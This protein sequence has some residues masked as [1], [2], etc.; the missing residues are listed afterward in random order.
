MSD[1]AYERL[2]AALQHHGSKV[3]NAGADRFMAQCP[4][5][6][7]GRP[8]LS[9]RRGDRCTL[10]YCFAGCDTAAIMDALGLTTRDL[11]DADKITYSYGD[12]LRGF[13]VTRSTATKDFRQSGATQGWTDGKPLYRLP[14]VAVAVQ[15][16]A[17]VWFTEGEKDA[18]LIATAGGFATTN[19]GGADNAHTADFTP[20]AGAHVRVLSDLDTA[21]DKHRESVVRLA[22]AAGAASVSVWKVKAGKDYGDHHAAGYG[23]D[24]L[25]QAVDQPETEG[26]RRIILTKAS[27]IEPLPTTWLWANRLPTGALAL[28]AGPEGTGK[29]T[30]GYSLAAQITRGTLPGLHLGHPRNVIVAATEDSWARTIVP[31]LMAASAD[32]DR[33]YRIEVRTVLDVGGYLTLPKDVPGLEQA[34]HDTA[35]VLLLL[36]PL[37]SRLEAGLD[38][39]KDAETRR[40]LEPVAA[41]AERTGLA[42]VGLI[43]FNKGGSADVLNNVMASKA[44]TAV[45]RSVST[46]IRDPDDDTGRRRIFGTP[47]CN[48]GRDDLPL[49]PFR[50]EEHTFLNRAGDLV[51]TSRV[52]WLAEQQGT[53]ADLMRQSRDTGDQTVVAEVA[54]WLADY[55]ETQGGSAARKN[56]VDAARKERFSED[57]LKRGFKRLGLK[58][59]GDGYPR[60][61]YWMT[62]EA[63]AEWDGA[64]DGSSQ[65]TVGAP[66]RGESLTTPTTPTRVRSEQSE[67]SEQSGQSPARVLQLDTPEPDTG[68]VCANPPCPQRL[69]AVERADG[70]CTECNRDARRKRDAARQ[71]GQATA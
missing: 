44:F 45:A 33:V 9:V 13:V 41:T 64:H 34:V 38:T 37:M 20:L 58:Y 46:V 70:L 14:A 71:K 63:A 60:V 50:I 23:V 35:A 65:G 17:P 40:A 30:V 55:L 32:L 25:E 51:A 39:H 42:V 26:L 2:R 7:D 48:L 69:T 8:S 18:D 62:A 66:V 11:Y 56:I 5:H 21:G 57:Q 53:V 16:G 54:D 10:V 31:R 49:L 43:H 52:E 61:T 22:L 28:I 29:S 59:R 27:S 47:K 24:D 3:E 68:A 15:A 6:D 1:D 19:A 12:D 4:A 36:D 67:Q